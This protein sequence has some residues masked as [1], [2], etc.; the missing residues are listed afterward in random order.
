MHAVIFYDDLS[1]QAVAYRQMS[2]LL[3]R[4]PGREAY[5]GDVFYLHSRLLERAAKMNDSM[6]AGSLTALPVIETQA[7]D[8]SAYIPTN[9][10]SITDGQIFLE[11]ELFY[12]GIRPAV[13]VGLSVS[14]VGSAAQIKAMK[15]VAGTIKLELAQ[16]REMAAFAQFASDLDAST[17]RLLAR[18]A[19]LTEL[20]KQ[21]QYTPLPVEEQVAV[22]FAGVKGYADK[23][24]IG[25]ITRFESQ[26]L[27]AI[28]EKGKDILAK[29]RSEKTI[30]EET[31]G[32]LKAFLDDF[33][34][35]FA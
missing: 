33:V 3:R 35:T 23:I 30:S 10:I 1:K 34:K 21:P 29:I 2:L 22:I 14:R 19:R 13:N 25:D 18:G 5:P 12:K 20:L 31:D 8:V 9:V 6:G 16:Y 11:T 28:R 32:K 24:A 27:D 7:G 17:Q 15:Q 26:Y 4:P